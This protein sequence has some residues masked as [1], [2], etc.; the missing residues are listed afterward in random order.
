MWNLMV[1]W[2][3]RRRRPYWS[4]T[5]QS[6][7]VALHSVHSCRRLSGQ[8]EMGLT[9]HLVVVIATE[10]QGLVMLMTEMT[11]IVAYITSNTVDT[12]VRPSVFLFFFF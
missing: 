1:R 7:P 5:E 12:S 6:R 8:L 2:G 10:G 9:G 3:L 11:V 4:Q